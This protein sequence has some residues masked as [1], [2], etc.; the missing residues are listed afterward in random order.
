M[1]EVELPCV[2]SVGVELAADGRRVSAVETRQ[3]GL[4]ALGLQMLAEG[5]RATC[6]TERRALLAVEGEELR[7]LSR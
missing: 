5:R 1:I 3:R 2:R 4:L 6:D 7:R